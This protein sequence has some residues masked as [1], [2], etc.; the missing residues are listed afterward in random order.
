MLTDKLIVVIFRPHQVAFYC[1]DERPGVADSDAA[2]RCGVNPLH[3]MPGPTVAGSAQG[4]GRR[5]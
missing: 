1:G 4:V 3:A 2:E 5:C